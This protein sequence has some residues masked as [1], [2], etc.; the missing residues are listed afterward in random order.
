M[1]RTDQAY[2]Q[3][4]NPSRETVPLLFSALLCGDTGI[5]MLLFFTV[6]KG[7]KHPVILGLLVWTEA[8][9]TTDLAKSSEVILKIGESVAILSFFLNPN[10]S[11]KILP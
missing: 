11:F 9:F 3:E 8:E 7:V 4:P 5:I 6:G 1:S 10:I 2:P